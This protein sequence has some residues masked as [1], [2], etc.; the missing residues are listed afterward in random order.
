MSHS[1]HSGLVSRK[2]AEIAFA[3]LL[4]GFGVAI[5]K[6]AMELDTEWGGSGPE[7]GY[8][9]LR[10]GYLIL[11]ASLALLVL[12]VLKTGHGKALFSREAA[13]NIGLFAL[14]LLA[15]VAVVPF[16]GLYLAAAAYLLITIGLLGRVNWGISVGVATIFPLILFILF[17]FFFRTPLPKGPLGPLLGMH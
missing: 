9:P 2:V 14:P 10:V 7:A 12:E 4:L 6:G 1:D 13:L 8:F 5:I 3:I 15:L 16:L 17:E 11:I